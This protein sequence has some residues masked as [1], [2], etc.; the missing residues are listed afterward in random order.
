MTDFKDLVTRYLTVWNTGDQADRAALVQIVFTED[1]RYVDPLADT[2]GHAGMV[3]LVDGVR[4]MFP[5]LEFRPSGI[6]DGHHDVVRF[7][8]QLGPA[9]GEPLAVGFDVA[10]LAEDGRIRSV[11]GFLDKAP[12]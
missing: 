2:G 3:E 1:V 12:G 6:V 5:G 10:R 8:W 11:Y 9:E 7:G 4:A